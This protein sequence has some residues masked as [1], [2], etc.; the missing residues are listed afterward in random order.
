MIEA[1]LL[2][3]LHF[4]QKE[5]KNIACFDLQ[6]FKIG[7]MVLDISKAVDQEDFDINLK[8]K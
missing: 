2:N 6:F 4:P 8:A 7:L 1:F 5:A 3:F